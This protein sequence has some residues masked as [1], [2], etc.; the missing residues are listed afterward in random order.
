MEINKTLTTVED[1]VRF[2]AEAQFV[3]KGIKYFFMNWAQ[4]NAEVTMRNVKEPTIVYVLPSSGDFDINQRRSRIYDAPEAQLAF[5]A[6]AD[7]DFIA[8]DNDDVVENM[9]RLAIAFV[10]TLNMSGL[11]EPIE[12]KLHYQVIYD[13]FDDNLTGVVIEPILKETT[14]IAFCVDCASQDEDRCNV[15]KQLFGYEL[16]T[17][18]GKTTR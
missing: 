4:L 8:S 11:F 13:G 15:F 5:L 2:I 1:K 16:V 3:P 17:Q 7:F 12:N 18:D 14:G 6:P 10:E 9:K